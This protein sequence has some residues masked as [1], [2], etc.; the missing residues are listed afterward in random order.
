M[1]RALSTFVMKLSDSRISYCFAR[2]FLLLILVLGTC[3]SVASQQGPTTSVSFACTAQGFGQ[4]HHPVRTVN[5]EAQRLF[6]QALA[7]D[8]GFNHNQAEQC[9][10]R[11]A[12]LDPKMSMAYWGIA[13][14]LGTNYNL[15]VDDEREKIAYEMVQKALALSKGG[16]RN[17][18]DY[19]QALAKRYTNEPNPDYNRLEAAY[20]DAMREVYKRYR[21]DLDAATLFA[22]SGMNMHPWKLYTHDGRPNPGTE[23]I[24]GVL[25]GVLKRDPSHLGANHFY[26][27]AVEASTHPQTGLPSAQRLA[28]LAPASG[29]LVHMP[30]HIFIR[31]GDHE[32]GEKTNVAAAR[33]DEAYFA[34]AHPQGIYPLMYYTHNLHFIAVE[35]AFM[36]N[37]AQSLDYARRVQQF[38]G[39]HV[40]EMDMLDAFYALPLLIMVR[41]HRWSDIL[42]E[43]QPDADHPMSTGVWHF[44]RALADSGTG[45]LDEAQSELGALRSLAPAMAKISIDPQGPR[46]SEVIP[47]IMGH[48]VEAHI[49][50]AQSQHDATIEHLRNAVLLEDSLDYDEPP[51]WFYPMRE[52]L[53]AALLATGKPAE[54]EGVFREDLKHNQGNPRSLFGLAE[55]L[56]AEGRTAEAQ[57][58][59]KQFEQT[60]K[61]ADVKL[62][63]SAL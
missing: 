23:E 4:V 26:I 14:V 38:V 13:L 10:R 33:A 54:A 45:K 53:G 62:D 21:D 37:Y 36:G 35:N 2:F 22:E 16:P 63:L 3:F 43:P 49:S 55:S 42:S 58:V 27:H 32:D 56:N 5:P 40:K 28:G 1:A 51:D 44:A 7:L 31:T 9:F 17:E 20:H 24:V 11:A 8:Y 18:R 61:N 52:P 46:N 34:M 39:P 25:Q 29:H 50:A 6:E 41:F 57:A 15:P 19:I 60:W 59:R 47:Q 30:A 12:D 48:L